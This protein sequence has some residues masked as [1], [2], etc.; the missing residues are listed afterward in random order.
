MQKK[1]D[2]QEKRTMA[3]QATQPDDDVVTGSSSNY[4]DYKQD[5]GM[6]EIRKHRFVR[7]VYMLDTLISKLN[8][9]FFLSFLLSFV[10]CLLSTPQETFERFLREHSIAGEPAYAHVLN[11]ATQNDEYVIVEVPLSEV[12]RFDPDLADNVVQNTLRY[13]KIFCSVLDEKVFGYEEPRVLYR[14]YE[15]R[16]LPVGRKGQFP[17]FSSNRPSSILSDPKPEALSV[18]QIKSNQV[19]KLTTVTGM[20]VKSSDVQPCCVVATYICEHCQTEIHQLIP[21]HQ[22]EF[23]PLN[24]CDHCKKSGTVWPVSRG[25]KFVKYQTLKVQEL[26]NQVPMGQVPRSLHCWVQN[27]LT[28]LVTP[29]AIVTMDAIVIPQRVIAKKTRQAAGLLTTTVLHCQSILLHKNEALATDLP[30]QVAI[31]VQAI[32]QC[33][34]PL[35][36]LARSIAPEIYGHRDIKLALW[37]MLVGGVT[38][39]LHDGMTI[40]GT[41]NV[42]LMGDPGVA[43]SQ[44]LKFLSKLAPRGVYTTGKGSSGVGLTAAITKDEDE[45]SLEGGALVLSDRGKV[46]CSTRWFCVNGLVRIAVDVCIIDRLLQYKQK[47]LHSHQVLFYF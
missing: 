38:R 27:E 12:K 33:D 32:A 10:S 28:R 20:V 1:K 3:S 16:I 31:A 44:L 21:A 8:S 36:K 26:S 23:L 35:S 46:V 4:P 5:A 7:A 25:S 9:L 19:G 13:H 34:D 29:G 15:L 11:D 40:R 43:K 6:Y 37:L 42:L 18:R 22:R 14:N 41:L 30:D 2:E 39:K 47:T 17:P 45:L 24:K